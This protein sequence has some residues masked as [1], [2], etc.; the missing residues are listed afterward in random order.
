MKKNNSFV[1]LAMGVMFGAQMHADGIAYSFVKAQDSDQKIHITS[2][3][4]KKMRFMAVEKAAGDICSREEL[5]SICLRHSPE[6]AVN[7]GSF[8]RGGRFNGCPHGLAIINSYP[9]TDA[10]F[11]R[12]MLLIDSENKTVDMQVKKITWSVKVGDQLIVADRINQPASSNDVVVFDI[13]FGSETKTSV[14]GIELVVERGKLVQIRTFCGSASVAMQGYVVRI[15]LQHPLA[16]VDWK[17]YLAQPCTTKITTEMLDLERDGFSAIQGLVMLVDEGKIVGNWAQQLSDGGVSGRLAD[18]YGVDLSNPQDCDDFINK[19]NA[20]AA[21]GITVD[22]TVKII[23]FEGGMAGWQ[24][25]FNIANVAKIMLGLGCV[26]AMLLGSGGDVGL[27][28]RDRLVVP[29]SGNDQM[30]GRCEERPIS[31]AILFFEEKED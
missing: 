12:P 6:V 24:A 29:P 5:S 18:E 23:A 30:P 2:I 8:R 31:T 20:H 25:G 13:F 17:Q 21:L 22:G 7:S 28:L 1:I 4:P 16:K 27:W 26:K 3:D 11:L 14:E 10:G 19:P 15:G 9:Y